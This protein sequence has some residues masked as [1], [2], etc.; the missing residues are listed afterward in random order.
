MFSLRFDGASKYLSKIFDD[1]WMA[2]NGFL[3]EPD[4]LGTVAELLRRKKQRPLIAAKRGES[5]RD[6]IAA[7]RD[8]GVSQMP[9]LE[10][11]GGR[12]CGIVS[13]GDVVKNRLDE[14]EYEARSLR[15]FIAGA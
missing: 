7:M 6:V 1:K 12:L 15:S 11:E 8:S 3:D 10:S 5:V 14:V 9:V 4:P 13:I 2:E